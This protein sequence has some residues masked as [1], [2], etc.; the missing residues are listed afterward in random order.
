MSRTLPG[1]APISRLPGRRSCRARS[2]P[3]HRPNDRTVER[4]AERAERPRDDR[5]PSRGRGR[6]SIGRSPQVRPQGS[7]RARPCAGAPEPSRSPDRAWRQTK[8][9]RGGPPASQPARMRRRASATPAGGVRAGGA[10]PG[11]PARCESRRTRRGT[12]PSQ[13]LPRR[14]SQGRRWI[15][16]SLSSRPAQDSGRRRR[17]HRPR[18][19][20]Q[21]QRPTNVSRPLRPE[22]GAAIGRSTPRR[23]RRGKRW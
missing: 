17:P 3:G 9:A 5:A 20:A 10:L 8:S 18:A 21:A 13:T 19:S 2:Q 22:A 23:A 14:P 16:A 6:P 7:A 15:S 4:P 1:L 12:A 11:V